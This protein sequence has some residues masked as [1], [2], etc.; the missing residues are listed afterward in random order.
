MSDGQ[1]DLINGA[2]PEQADKSKGLLQSKTLWF[3]AIVAAIPYVANAA[4]FPVPP[5]EVCL[6]IAAAGNAALRMVT[7]KPVKIKG[8]R[9]RVVKPAS[10]NYRAVLP[11]R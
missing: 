11:P 6:A 3:N 2:L 8:K 5:L 10:E 1:D 7:T 9:S 4:G